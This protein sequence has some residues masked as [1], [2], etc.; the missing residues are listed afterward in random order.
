[1]LAAYLQRFLHAETRGMG[2]GS[3][4]VR[5]LNASAARVCGC[6][7]HGPCDPVTLS[8]NLDNFYSQKRCNLWC[9]W[10]ELFAD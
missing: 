5:M 3:Q 9:F 7:G 2:D 8:L 1:M 10:A 6:H 4:P